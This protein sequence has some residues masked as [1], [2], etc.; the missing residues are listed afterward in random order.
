MGRFVAP[1]VEW[2]FPAEIVQVHRTFLKR[3]PSFG[4]LH[5]RC[6]VAVIARDQEIEIGWRRAGV[7]FAIHV[8]HVAGVIA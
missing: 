1:T 7:G 6:A 4:D 3:G 8:D 5:H 2:R